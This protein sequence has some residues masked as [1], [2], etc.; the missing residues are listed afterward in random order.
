MTHSNP[1]RKTGRHIV[2]STMGEEV[3]AFI[4]AP[5]PPVPAL[6]LGP[7]QTLM[8]ETNL[9]LGRLDGMN[10]TLPDPQMFVYMYA[11]KEAVLSAQIE[12]TQSSL[13]DLLRFDVEGE[14]DVPIDDLLEA[15]LYV[16][17]MQYGIQKLQEGMPVCNRLIKEVH[18][19]LLATG[20]GSDKQP[21]EFRRS[22]NWIG[23]TR[24]GNA[25]YVPPPPN[26]VNDCMSDLEKFIHKPDASIPLLLKAALAHV[27]IESIHPFLDGNGRIG[28][29]LIT[30]LL[31]AGGA[32]QQP[33]LYLSLFLKNHRGEYYDLLQQVREKGAWESW[34]EFFLTGVKETSQ[35]ATTSAQQILRLYEQDRASIGKLGRASGSMLRVHDHMQAQ[36]FVQIPETAKALN[37]SAPTV[38]KALARLEHLR[39]AKEITGKQRGQVFAYDKYLDILTEGTE[40]L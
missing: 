35:Q 33:I 12:G 32:L 24:P 5:L 10:A 14:S 8:A 34:I 27:Q 3:R 7:L 29:M 6:R 15:S 30:F 1:I 16:T 31:Y 40:P 23:G 36:L 26:V 28:R 21:G 22:Q 37:L 20:R 25:R 4:P 9:A 17:A 13:A 39:I 2:N 11:R 18:G 38:S 19:K